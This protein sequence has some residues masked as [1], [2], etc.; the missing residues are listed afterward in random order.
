[1]MDIFSTVAEGLEAPARIAFPIV[2][3][4]E[5]DLVCITRALYIGIGGD[6]AVAMAD[7]L[8]VTFENVPAGTILPIRVRAVRASGTSAGAILGLV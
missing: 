6:V 7:L 1:M 8:S 4:D 3:A 5:H 2:P